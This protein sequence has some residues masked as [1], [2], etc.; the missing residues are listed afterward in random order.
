M[1]AGLDAPH[2]LAFCAGLDVLS[3]FP[4]QSDHHPEYLG[5]APRG[6]MPGHPSS[7][8]GGTTPPCSRSK[9]YSVNCGFMV[10]VISLENVSEA[11]KFKAE[12][13]VACPFVLDP[14]R[15]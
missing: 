14:I 5:V 10:I 8:G 13:M 6:G 11:H 3:V 4:Q 1:A 9:R 2:V 12:A 15:F 7:S